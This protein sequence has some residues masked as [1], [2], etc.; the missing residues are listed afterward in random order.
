M[1]SA[2]KAPDPYKQAEAQRQENAY[3][4]QYNTI[5]SNANQ[6]TPYGTI[7]NSPGAQIPI[8]DDK[9][10]VTGYGTQWNQTTSLSPQEQAIFN[11][12]QA[13]R[14]SLQGFAG[15]QLSTLSNTLGKAF[16][17]AGLPEW[18]LYEKG[19]ELQQA[20]YEGTD[21]KAIEDAMMA[22][23]RRA[24][25]PVNQ[26][27]DAQLAARGMGAPGSNAGYKIDQARGDVMSEAGRNAYLASGAESRA[28]AGES[29]NVAEFMNKILQ[30]GWLNK[31][32]KADQQNTV[33]GG[34]FGERQQERN[35]IVNELAALM[36]GGQVMV[37]QAT[38]FQGSQTNP[39]DIAGA[40]QTK[41]SQD[42]QAYQNKQSGL[43]GLLGAG[44]SIA[45]PFLGAAAG[46]LTKSMGW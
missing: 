29:R 40:I 43:F 33:R 44:L 28:A 7:T 4:S 25:E 46:G 21:R 10:N 16:N 36:G 30:Q 19:P 27:Q 20:K 34:M 5:G 12:E 2:P 31:N 13:N 1:G 15:Q 38:A 11:Q 26:A 39:F 3:T 42:Q 35:Q 23:T 18:Q 9:G 6:Y 37:P 32:L 8:Y 14:G 45:N 41:Y 22:S 24:V 17:T